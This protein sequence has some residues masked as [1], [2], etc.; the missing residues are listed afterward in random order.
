MGTRADYYVG[1]GPDAEW[2]GSTAWDGYPHG[3]FEAT[4]ELFPATVETWREWVATL[5]A[6]RGDATLPGQG[7][8]WPWDNSR[9]TD[10]SYAWDR[11][12]I[13][14]SEFGHSWF[15]LDPDAEDF[16]QSEDDADGPKVDFPD[17]SARKAV[18]LGP[19]SGV[20][21]VGIRQDDES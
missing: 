9:T 2:L 8:P 21:V 18:T 15:R 20:I 1:R 6:G 5:L 12:V 10:F 3:V 16:G 7:W 11:G 4:P 14:G 17:M 13:W 19:R